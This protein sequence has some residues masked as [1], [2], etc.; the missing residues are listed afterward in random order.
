VA[1]CGGSA[2]GDAGQG[3]ETGYV[4]VAAEHAPVTEGP[5]CRDAGTPGATSPCALPRQGPEYYVD[6]GLKYF[7]TLDVAADPAS[8]PHYAELVARW[9]WP[10]WLKL[11]GFGRDHLIGTAKL[12]KQ[13]DPSTVPVRDCRAFDVQPFCRC[14]VAFDY[15]GSRCPI[16]E[17]FTFNDQGEMTFIEAWSDLPGLLPGDPATDRWGE[18]A[19]FPRLSTR[20]PGLGAG[21]GRFDVDGPWMHAAEAVDAD[22]ADFAARARDP[23][24]TWADELKAA[25]D[26]LYT[27]GC[28]W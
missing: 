21:D 5:G 15:D 11:T 18:S 16:Y 20:V 2:E 8:A 26:D 9:E 23:W 22:V 6:Q 3:D 27:R 25:G 14:V 4:E 19:G 24:A 13:V 17:E 7:D 10:P 1:A 12:L 28:G